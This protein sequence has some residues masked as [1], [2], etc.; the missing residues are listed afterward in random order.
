MERGDIVASLYLPCGQCVG[1]RLERSRQ[2]AMRCMHEASLYKRNCFITLTYRDDCLPA[3]GSLNYRDFQLFMKRLRKSFPNSR[4]RFYMCG[5]YGEDFNRPH[6]HACLFNFDFEDK[7][8]VR[9]LSGS[10]SKLFKSKTLERL[11]PF[12]YGSIGAVTFESAAYVARYVMKKVNGDRAKDHYKV[13][14]SDGVITWRTPEFNKM[15]LRPGIGAQWMERF[16]SDVYPDGNVVVRGHESKS[17][18]Y[19]DKRYS[20]LDPFGHE[21]MIFERELASLERWEDQT[22]ERLKVREQVATA[23][24]R[25]LKRTLS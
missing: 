7:V 17:P 2:W 4:I 3:N 19:Y 22:D 6:F 15:S 8:P 12:G 1:C 11:W 25:S 5:E 24:I 16:V 23:R 10:G 21:A 18:R 20:K 13:V 14:D 9:L